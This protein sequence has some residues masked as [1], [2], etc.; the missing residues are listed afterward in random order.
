MDL[1]RRAAAAAVLTVLVSALGGCAT[2]QQQSVTAVAKRFYDAVQGGDAGSACALLAPSTLSKLEQSA[3][4]PCAEALLQEDVPGPER[5]TATQVF[6]TM[7]QVR[8]AGDT[9]FL[10][11]SDRGWLVLAVACGARP[12]SPDQPFDCRVGGA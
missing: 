3:G 10:T 5:P 12:A 8:Y 11:R 7:A 4:K 2:A 1:P 9:A 6:G